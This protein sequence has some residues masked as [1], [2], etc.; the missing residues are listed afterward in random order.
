[1]RTIFACFNDNFPLNAGHIMA[2]DCC[3]WQRLSRFKLPVTA[4]LIGWLTCGMPNEQIARVRR[5]NGRFFIFP[6]ISNPIANEFHEIKQN[7]LNLME[8]HAVFIQW[9]KIFEFYLFNRL[10]CL[11][12]HLR[13]RKF[14]SSLSVYIFYRNWIKCYK[15]EQEKRRKKSHTNTRTNHDYRGTF[16]TCLEN[17]V[18]WRSSSSHCAFD[19]QIK[20]TFL[21]ILF[22]FCWKQILHRGLICGKLQSNKIIIIKPNEWPHIISCRWFS[23]C[24]FSMETKQKLVVLAYAVR[25]VLTNCVF[26]STDKNEIHQKKEIFGAKKR[27]GYFNFLVN[28]FLTS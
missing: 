3:V 11:P 26:N 17:Q 19:I 1:M 14:F 22:F 6:N 16:N 15:N 21:A 9:I 24:W 12:A 18:N 20:Y 8:M 28:F 5:L 7:V 4:T 2:S 13:K 23:S 10:N 27:R 25:T